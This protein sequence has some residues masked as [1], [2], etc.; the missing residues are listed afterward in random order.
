MGQIAVVVKTFRVF[1]SLSRAEQVS[2]DPTFTLPYAFEFET[3]ESACS[4]RS[5][6]NDGSG[7]RNR[8]CLV[9]RD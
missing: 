9:S 3:S 7:E 5:T 1:A 8:G 2:I 4:S 6:I